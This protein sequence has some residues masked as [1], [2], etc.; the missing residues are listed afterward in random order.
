MHPP[1]TTLD[2]RP[3]MLRP[4]ILDPFARPR[5]LKAGLRRDQKIG[6]I[7][8]Q[9][10]GDETLGNYGPVSVGS[11]DEIDSQLHCA[12]Q[13]SDRLG[14]IGRLSPDAIAWELHRA[15]AEPAN[16]NVADEKCSAC[17]SQ[18][19][20]APARRVWCCIGGFH[21]LLV[22]QPPNRPG[23]IT[24][25]LGQRGN[26]LCRYASVRKLPP[27]DS[28]DISQSSGAHRPTH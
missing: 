20:I 3:Q 24:P 11:V 19:S 13:N 27:R 10:L 16:R 5:P 26:A 8:M 15:V 25:W 6:W 2:C 7:R 18:T 22:S 17:F 21:D 1:K 23:A 12:S 9:C 4:A 14:M 28:A